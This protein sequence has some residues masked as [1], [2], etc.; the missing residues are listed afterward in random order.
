M[1][2][3][4]ED[5][6]ERNRIPFRPTSRFSGEDRVNENAEEWL[7]RGMADLT[8]PM[9]AQAARIA[10]RGQNPDWGSLNVYRIP[11]VQEPWAIDGTPLALLPIRIQNVQTIASGTARGS[12]NI[13]NRRLKACCRASARATVRTFDRGGCRSASTFCR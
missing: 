3:P 12:G 13:L 7:G 6:T 4:L 9:I 10:A 1:F 5:G 2:E 8:Y 11:R